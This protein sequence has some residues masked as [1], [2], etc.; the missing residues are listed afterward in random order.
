MV[1]III[2]GSSR[3]EKDNNNINNNN[4]R[5]DRKFIRILSLDNISKTKSSTIK[6]SIV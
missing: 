4:K 2:I 6:D 5:K 1:S 3:V